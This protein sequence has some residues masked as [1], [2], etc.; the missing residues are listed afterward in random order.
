MEKM[1][2]IFD[3]ELSKKFGVRIKYALIECCECGR[4]FGVNLIDNCLRPDQLICQSCAVKKIAG[5]L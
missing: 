2:Q 4:T 5:E 3:N 1:I